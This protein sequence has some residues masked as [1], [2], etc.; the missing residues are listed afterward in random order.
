MTLPKPT[1][2]TSCCGSKVRMWHD[3]GGAD[4]TLCNECGH[5]TCSR[6]A[7]SFSSEDGYDDDGQGVRTRAICQAC[8]AAAKEGFCNAERP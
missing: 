3:D 2:V 5:E 1:P 8:A 4:E 6:C 7:A